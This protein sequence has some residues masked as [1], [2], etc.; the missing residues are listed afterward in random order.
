MKRKKKPVRRPSTPTLPMRPKA[1]PRTGSRSSREQLSIQQK[2]EATTA[3]LADRARG[4][5]NS[6]LGVEDI[7]SSTR[8]DSMALL[9][10]KARDKY[11]RN[12]SPVKE[13]KV[14][15]LL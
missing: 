9:G 4:P 13:N 15:R 1:R 8:V 14:R 10:T 3:I 12:D 7:Q 6:L 11:Y 5:E 2:H